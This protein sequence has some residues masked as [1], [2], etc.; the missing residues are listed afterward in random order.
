[1]TNFLKNSLRLY[2]LLK[3]AVPSKLTNQQLLEYHRKTHMLYQ[4]NIRHRPPN[5]QFIN[6][7]VDLHDSFVKEILRRG[8]NHK[9]PLKKIP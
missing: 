3:D 1:M 2:K 4:G 8:M 9:S 5:K 6:M 7:I